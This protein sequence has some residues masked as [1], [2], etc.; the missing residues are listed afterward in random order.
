MVPLV[1]ISIYL[2]IF[3][4]YNYNFNLFKKSL[5]ESISGTYFNAFLN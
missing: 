4:D 2:I 5:D 3:S 1:L